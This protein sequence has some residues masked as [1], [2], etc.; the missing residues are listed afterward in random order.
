[1]EPELRERRTFELERWRSVAA[2]VTETANS[3]F[4]GL[5]AIKYFQASQDVKGVLLTNT[6][7][8]MLISPIVLSVVAGRGWPAGKGVAIF[9]AIAALMCLLAAFPSLTLFV[10][11]SILAYM[12]AA[13]VSPLYLAIYEGNYRMATRGQLFAK[14]YFLRIISNIVF[15]FAAGW[16]LEQDIRRYPIVLL[17]YSACFAFSSWCAA[18]MPTVAMG[19]SEGRHPLRA[20]R[21][22]K[23]D[24]RFRWT[25]LS[26][27][28]LGFA[29][30][31]MF[32]LRTEYLANPV[33][34]INLS[35]QN[36]ALYTAVIPN[37][38]RLCFNPI[39]G[40]IFDRMNFFTLRIILNTGFML[41]FLSFFTGSSHAG[42]ITG[43]I[44]FGIANA[45]ADIVWNLWVTKIAPPEKTAEYMAVHTFLTGVR[46]VIAPVLA[47]NLTHLVPVRHIAMGCAAL[48]V[49][50][51]A[52]LWRERKSF[53]PEGDTT[54]VA[55]VEP[56]ET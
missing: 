14:N 11:C 39:W 54:P 35:T 9:S 48:V 42:L 32:P 15:A 17:A 45:G 18:K 24:R 49:A 4:L 47:F 2:G 23:H 46:G 26:W 44:L 19:S 8:G 5:V 52:L 55:P 33:Y 53:R 56:G 31:A 21:H 28:L 12:A 16:L 13:A 3:T 37:I 1:M 20:L 51:S 10:V 6:S 40:P 43:A 7:L 27:M 22:V 36:V 34:K 25:L 29:N 30:L 41:G 38:A 50:A